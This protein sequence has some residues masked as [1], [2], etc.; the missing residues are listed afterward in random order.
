MDKISICGTSHLRP[1]KFTFHLSLSTVEVCVLE[2]LQLSSDLPENV[3]ICMKC[4][5][6]NYKKVF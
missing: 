5:V 3:K 4:G 6:W 1:S 2:L